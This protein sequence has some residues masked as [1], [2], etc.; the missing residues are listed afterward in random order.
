MAGAAWFAGAHRLLAPRLGGL[1]GP[2]TPLAR[3]LLERHLAI[4]EQDALGD[5]LRQREINAEW[6]FMGRT[7][8]VLALANAALREPELKARALA[9]MDRILDDTL[10]REEAEGMEHFLMSYGHHGGWKQQPPRSLFVDGEIALMLAA[11][12]AVEERGGWQARFLERAGF[13]RERMEGGP[14]L[15]GESYPDECWLF[16]NSMALAALELGDRLDGTDHHAFATRWLQRARSELVD[17]VTGLLPS[18]TTWDGEILDGPE[19]SSIWLVCHC[20]ELVDPAFARDQYTRAR[21]LLRGGVLGFG[22]AREWP[23]TWRGHEDVDSGPIIPILDASTSSSGLAIIPAMGF[24]DH[25]FA[26]SLGASLNLMG[27][28]SE[29]LGGTAFLASNQ[30]GDAV[31][32]YALCQG[33]LWKLGRAS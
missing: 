1:E 10:E 20:L 9:V 8:L 16:C 17:P 32:A 6:D 29:R 24:E 22:F 14:A 15:L 11:R 28:P 5:A 13:I 26:R 31:L 18:S 4:W 19:G 23:S 2:L 3:A 30:V 12:R 25:A 33:P 27:F 7:F 21:A